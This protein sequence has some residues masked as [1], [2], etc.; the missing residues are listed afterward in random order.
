[1]KRELGLARCGLACCLCSENVTCKGCK[2]D[3]FKDLSWCKDA[4]FCENRK[5]CIAK[6]VAACWVCDDSSCRKGLFAEKIKARGFT[7][8][9]RRY[10]VEALLDRLEANE[11]AGIVYH[12]EGIMGDYDE[13]DDVESLIDFI[14]TG[15]R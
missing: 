11:K 14:N 8:Y 5:C 12:R 3:G 4:D 10:G 1:M 6:D 13:F 7:E 9:A 2:A 15:K